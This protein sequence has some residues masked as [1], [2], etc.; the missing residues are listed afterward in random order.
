MSFNL[1]VALQN[2][3]IFLG[4][5]EDVLRTRALKELVASGSGGDDFD[6]EHLECD[7]PV[8]SWVAS[9]G[10]APFL[11]PRRTVVVR[12]VNRVEPPDR[13]DLKTLP[14]T[15]LLILVGDDE[16]GDDS[17]Q[18][19]FGSNRDKWAKYVR[20]GGGYAE[21]F[22]QDL[23]ALPA[24][25]RA[26]AKARGFQLQISNANLLAEMV[27]GSLSRAN[28]ELD[29]LALFANASGEI[30]DRAIRQVVVASREYNVF[31]LV[32]SVVS[33]QV[34]Q[35]LIQLRNLVG[36][37]DK[38]QDAAISG[39]IPLVHR[40]YRLIWQARAVLD[41]GNDLAR[42]KEHF[43]SKP[44]YATEPPYRQ[45]RLMAVARKLESDA[46]ARSIACVA[47]ADGKLKG[48]LTGYSTMDTLE[49]L[50][51][52]LA[53]FAKGTD[54]IRSPETSYA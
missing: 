42:A 21:E 9:A 26:E 14:P 44:N 51:L 20:A 3:V 29:K 16:N 7:S 41:L 10:T 15:A 49:Q 27:G 30:D 38:A 6:L 47:E 48:M 33:G 19:K 36:S 53:A 2:S 39:I 25:I 28:E 17:R 4:G 35:S 34:A 43:L 8:D 54:A 1:E 52:N 32:E 24:L 50:V 37:T 13:N 46:I 18:R 5:E 45:A 23:K 40:H 22:K 12:H 31:N 11:S